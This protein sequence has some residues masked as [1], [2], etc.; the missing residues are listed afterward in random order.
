MKCHPL[1]LLFFLFPVVPIS[2]QNYEVKGKV[3]TN[4]GEP[5]PWVKLQVIGRM[6]GG[7]TDL[8][9]RFHL[10]DTVEIKTLEVSEIGYHTQEVAVNN[11]SVLHIELEENEYYDYPD[12]FDYFPKKPL[13]EESPRYQMASGLYSSPVESFQGMMAGVKANRFSGSPGASLSLRIRGHN[14]IA[15]SN[16]PLYVINGMEMEGTP[17]GLLGATQLAPAFSDPLR[18]ILAKNISSIHIL[19]G[20]GTARY[21]QRGA[22]GVVLIETKENSHNNSTWYYSQSISM[23]EIPSWPKLLDAEAYQNWANETQLVPNNFLQGQDQDWQ[24]RISRKAFSS[25]HRLTR[26]GNPPRFNPYRL[27][28]LIEG[29]Q[30]PIDQTSF[31]RL[32]LNFSTKFKKGNWRL[33]V[34]YNG[35]IDRNNQ[36]PAVA[37][38]MPNLDLLQSAFSMNPTLRDTAQPDA[39][40][41]NLLRIQEEVSFRSR[42]FNQLLSLHPSLDVGKSGSLTAVLAA[43]IKHERTQIQSPFPISF[44]P[45]TVTNNDQTFRHQRYWTSLT[46]KNSLGRRDHKLDLEIDWKSQFQRRFNI[47]GKLNPLP[48]F[49]YGDLNVRPTYSSPYTYPDLSVRAYHASSAE[50]YYTYRKFLRLLAGI[51]AE[52]LQNAHEF[53]YRVPQTWRLYPFATLS[54]NPFEWANEMKDPHSQFRISYGEPGWGASRTQAYHV[55]WDFHF[56]KKQ[57][58][59]K[60]LITGSLE[61][62]RKDISEKR[63][64]LATNDLGNL[65]WEEKAVGLVRNEGIE[66]KLNF[67]PRFRNADLWMETEL[68]VA[69]QRNELLR[70]DDSAFATFGTFLTPL[71]PTQSPR[72]LIPG[73]SIGSFA[74]PSYLGLDANGQARLSEPRWVGQALPQFIGGFHQRWHYKKWVF[75]YLLEGAAGF[76]LLNDMATALG[77]Q[78]GLYEGS[79]FSPSALE[80]DLPLFYEQP[81]ATDQLIEQGDY[82]RLK[83]INISYHHEWPWKDDHS[84]THEAVFSVTVQNAFLWTKYSGNDPEVALGPLFGAGQD[85]FSYPLARVWTLGVEMSF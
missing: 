9:G 48:P 83:N 47:N 59:W 75:S 80:S 27:S 55:A 20:A 79:N 18:Y 39:S 58:R 33:K 69:Y 82:L 2:A 31:Q 23:Q 26:L 57:Y 7:Y 42:G 63:F 43:E 78:G 71:L 5:I 51:R 11:R 53:Q 38:G 22:N 21:G 32:H 12:A 30:G 19:K 46:Y 64:A 49:G 8:D 61:V 76:Q 84:S 25:T 62:Y 65:I 41:Q 85:Y 37:H 3:T 35:S 68:N 66:F 4:W 44:D 6:N 56:D 1:L 50:A 34:F 72:Q 17:S 40:I 70:L 52:R 60:A 14:H 67:R 29:R 73:Q 45:V 74:L 28:V 54:I 77:R 16:E 24:K 13:S 15:N 10:K 36:L 81:F